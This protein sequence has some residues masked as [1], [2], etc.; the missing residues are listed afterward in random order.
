MPTPPFPRP[1]DAENAFYEALEKGD[2]EAMM[3]IWADDEDVVCIHPDGQRLCGHAQIR[4]GWQSLF[5]SAPRLTVRIGE[6][7]AWLGGMLAVH[8]LQETF[9]AEGDPEPRG[10]VLVTNVFIRGSDGWR[11]LSHH[12][13]PGAEEG[14]GDSDGDAQPRVLH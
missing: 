6:R 4:H 11:L 10:P 7:I 13:S 1:E 8:S 3:A 5:T 9:F 14:N 2:L 12:A